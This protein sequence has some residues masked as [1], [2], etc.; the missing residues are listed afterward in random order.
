[1]YDLEIKIM[2]DNHTKP[3]YDP[4][5]FIHEPIEIG[6]SLG[7][8]KH[9]YE[10]MNKRR[11]IRFFSDREVPFEIIENIV[12][13]AS[14]APSGAHIQPWTFVVVKDSEIKKQ[15]RVAAEKEE[16]ISYETRMTDEWLQALAPIGT[17]WEKPFLEVAPYL[18]VAFKQR[19]GY[20]PD[21][22]KKTHYYVNE[23]VGIAVGFLI[24]AIHNAGLVTLTHTPS[25][26]KFLSKILERPENEVPFVLL[27]IGYPADNATV[28]NL[29]RKSL[30]QV[31]VIR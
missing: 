5:P 21:G 30:D 12:K 23:S 28:P 10:Y 20:Y 3:G 31:M 9:Y 24:S 4:V 7:K 14:T 25:P 17:D 29:T 16:K 1:L 15:I 2:D 11:S 6:E 18:I 27:P 22:S 13:T 19:Y 8:A 26:M